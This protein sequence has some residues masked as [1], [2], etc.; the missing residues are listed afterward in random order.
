MIR[1][2]PN[3]AMCRM[4]P[5]ESKWDYPRGSKLYENGNLEKVID[6]DVFRHYK[7]NDHLETVAFKTGEDIEDVRFVVQNFL[8]HLIYAVCRMV[9]NYS[10]IVL[11]DCIEFHIRPKEF[12]YRV[13]YVNK[14]KRDYGT[15]Q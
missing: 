5:S 3:R 14:N 4:M 2:K 10:R 7:F 11:P 15:E 13:N 1:S 9:T 6:H 8:T 12:K